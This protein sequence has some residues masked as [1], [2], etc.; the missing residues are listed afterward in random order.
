MKDFLRIVSS[1][2]SKSF[3][4]DINTLLGLTIRFWFKVDL[5][6]YYVS[7]CPWLMLLLCLTMPLTYVTI[8]SH[9]ALA[10][11]LDNG[12]NHQLSL[13]E[14]ILYIWQLLCHEDYLCIMFKV[15]AFLVICYMRGLSISSHV[16]STSLTATFY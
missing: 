16:E 7:R 12:W 14:L 13:I 6:Y 5:F 2:L 8:M 10:Y 3:S 9:D 4:E 15:I 1:Y 11:Y